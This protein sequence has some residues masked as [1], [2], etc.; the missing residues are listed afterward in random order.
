MIERITGRLPFLL[1]NKKSESRNVLPLSNAEKELIAGFCASEIPIFRSDPTVV[2][3]F[4]Y[5]RFPGNF[6]ITERV[7]MHSGAYQFRS[8]DDENIKKHYAKLI[9]SFAKQR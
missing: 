9:K 6:E 7:I 4:N 2:E 1:L 3:T 8:F 5:P